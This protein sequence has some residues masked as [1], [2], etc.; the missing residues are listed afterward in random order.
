VGVLFRSCWRHLNDGGW[1]TEL[2]FDETPTTDA[3]RAGALREMV[4][5]QNDDVSLGEK[6][7]RTRKGLV[8]RGAVGDA[9]HSSGLRVL[10]LLPERLLRADGAARMVMNSGK[11][12]RQPSGTKIRVSEGQK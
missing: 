4:N 12:F 10:F 3:A 11:K 2:S 5:N 6:V 9:G 8:R 7:R 1:L